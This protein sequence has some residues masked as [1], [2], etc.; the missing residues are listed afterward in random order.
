[1]E[2]DL[3]IERLIERPETYRSLLGSLYGRNTQTVILRR[4]IL[5]NVIRGNIG[6]MYLNGS[7]G[8]EVLFYH[9]DKKY[10]I[11]IVSEHRDFK[12]YFCKSVNKIDRANI[13][14]ESPEEL[15]YGK[16]VKCNNITVFIGNI[17]KII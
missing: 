14:L 4:K 16:W 10:N 13:L 2:E 9:P 8:G 6:R 11:V 15:E 7:R 1:M 12:Y 17:I 3:I 5:R